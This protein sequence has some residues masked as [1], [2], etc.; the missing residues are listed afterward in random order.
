MSLSFCRL[1]PYVVACGPRNMAADEVLLESAA[2]GIPSLRFYGWSEAT[3]TLGYFQS[4]RLRHTDQALARLAYVRRP[5]GGATL[6]HH[7]E[8]TYALAL[9][10]G[11]VWHMHDPWLRQMHAIIAAALGEEDVACS[12]HRGTDKERFAGTLCFQHLTPGDLLIGSAKIAGSA[13][14]RQ[15]GALLQH[16]AILL[17]GSEYTPALPGIKELS[18]RT[19]PTDVMVQA[20]VNHFVCATGWRL[21]SEDWTG[22]ELERVEQLTD[23]K[24]TQDSWN[25]KR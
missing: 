21:V 6:V 15:R 1:L 19:I 5:T 10:A 18:G 24:Y 3:L 23:A 17:A 12:M 25:R 7:H 4:E 11:V 22:G 2:A 9:P 14:R 16:G 13:Q 8:L 20:V